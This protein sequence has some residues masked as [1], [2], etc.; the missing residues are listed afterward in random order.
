MSKYNN[1]AKELDKAF[2]EARKEYLSVYESYTETKKQF[3]CVP[4]INGIVNYDYAKKHNEAKYAFEKAKIEMQNAKNIWEKFN[5]RCR[6]LKS[7]LEN[8]VYKNN[9]INPE[10]V[11]SA[12]VELL[13]S[14]MLTG[15]D[16]FSLADKYDDNPTMLKLIAGYANEAQAKTQDKS[17]QAKL[18]VCVNTLKD[19]KSLSIKKFDELCKV[20]EYCSNQHDPKMANNYSFAKS[21]CEEWENITANSIENF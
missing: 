18:K 1:Y 11:D 5:Q 6:E 9:A 16:Y 14:G 2:K 12:T 19:G 10:S 17:E 15:D 7:N 20:A 13:K 4:Q 3:D 21:M 8:E